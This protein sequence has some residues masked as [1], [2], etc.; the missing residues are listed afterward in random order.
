MR[1]SS[2]S[3]SM[4]LA[5]AF[6]VS[7]L[8][9]GTASGAFKSPKGQ[10]APKY[11]AAYIVRDQFNAR[12]EQVE[13]VLS[14][15]Q[16]DAKDAGAAL[17]PHEVAINAD[18]LR[19]GNYILLWI[20]RDGSVS[21]NATF[22]ETMTQFG[23]AGE[24][25]K[26][27]L[28]TNSH[29]K[30]EGRIF[31][32]KGIKMRDGGSY[33]LDVKFSTV[34]TKPTMGGKLPADGGEPLKALDRLYK[35]VEKKDFKATSALLTPGTLKGLLSEYNDEAENMSSMKQAFDMWLP[36]KRKLLGGTTSGDSAILEVQG[37]P[38]GESKM[39]YL[40]KMV[41]TPAGWVFDQATPAGF[42][43]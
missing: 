33:S 16:F 25:L 18:A 34:V 14:E 7:P 11:A 15:L 36:K 23:D 27:E 41:K 4:A 5:S 39:L 38:Y 35:A 21:M 1:V 32:P 28:T 37:Q 29:D 40:I 17:A 42:I 13:L 22:S 6:L 24:N 2:I 30:V 9:G 43:D 20:N 26:S 8:I 12:N 3:A 31:T 10:I 19:K